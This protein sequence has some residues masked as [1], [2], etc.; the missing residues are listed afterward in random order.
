MSENILK[1]EGLSKVFRSKK[2]EIKAVK[3]VSLS[4]KQGETVG[5]VGESG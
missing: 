5:I 4:V 1:V 2:T 3:K